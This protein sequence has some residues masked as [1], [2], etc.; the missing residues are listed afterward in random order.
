MT[1]DLVIL[2]ADVQQEKTLETLLR[3]RWMALGIRTVSFDIFRHPR[4]DAGVC[5]EAHTFLRA[6]Q[7]SHTYAL[8]LLDREWSGSPGNST[9]LRTQIGGRMEQSGWASDRYVVIVAEPELEAWIWADSPVVAKELRLEWVAIHAL[10]DELRVWP[11]G[12]TKPDRPKELLETVLRRQRRPRSAALFQSL[13]RQVGLRHCSD[14]SF[15]LLR[16]TLERWF[17]Q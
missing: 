1:K 4:K 14:P 11:A 8:V 6:Y 9:T 7:R 3:E 15:V 13:A 2:T 17:A 5:H 10:A 16:E 12:K